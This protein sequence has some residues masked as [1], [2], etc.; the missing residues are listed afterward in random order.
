MQVVIDLLLGLTWR[1]PFL[2][3]KTKLFKILRIFIFLWSTVSK[4]RKTSPTDK[5]EGS[6]SRSKKR[7]AERH[8]NI[9]FINL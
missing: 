8:N 5:D 3:Q 7:R 9:L 4:N 6:I 2:K 1:K